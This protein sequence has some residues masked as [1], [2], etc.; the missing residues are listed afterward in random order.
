MTLTFEDY[1]RGAYY[2]Q[3]K[4]GRAKPSDLARRLNV[5]K[6]TVSL[7][8]QKL[9]VRRLLRHRPYGSVELTSKGEK[10]ARKLTYRHRLIEVFLTKVLN[11]PSDQVHKEACRLE[12]DFSEKSIQSIE[13]LLDHP[14]TDPHGNPLKE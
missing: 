1:V 8:V 10:L 2:L 9:S 13:K 5:S 4:N 11:V 7:M 3:Q 14:E 6:N 12:H